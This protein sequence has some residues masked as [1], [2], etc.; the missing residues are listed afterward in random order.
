MKSHKKYFCHIRYVTVKDLSYVII[1]SVNPLYLIVN[2]IKWYIEESNGNKCLTL[3][4]NDENKSALKKY[5]EV[6]S[7]IRDVIRSITNSL[8]SYNGK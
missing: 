5:E 4:P 8:G 3:V 2:K 6:C 1:N 7:K